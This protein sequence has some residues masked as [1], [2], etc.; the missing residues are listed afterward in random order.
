MS[1]VTVSSS[2]IITIAQASPRD[3]VSVA[4]ARGRR[5]TGIDWIRLA[6]AAVLFLVA[7]LTVLPAPIYAAWLVGLVAAEGGHWFAPVALLTLIP[8]WRR[9]A[10]GR[11]AVAFG[12]ASALLFGAP[13]LQAMRTSGALQAE[14]ART[15]GEAPLFAEDGLPPR[16]SPVELLDLYAGIPIGESRLRT[17][18]YASDAAGERRLDLYL[19][20]DSSRSAP[21]IVMVH[22]GSWRAGDRTELPALARYFAARG[23]AVAVPDYRLA[24]DHPFPAARNDVLAATDFVRLRAGALGIDR[25]RLVYIGRSAG[26][27]LAVSAAMAR[28]NDQAVRGAVSLYG[29]LDLRWGYANPGNPRVLDGRA[30]LRD[31]LG[32]TP[33]EVP[34]VYEA[35]SPVAQVSGRTPPVLLLHGGRDDLVSSEHS[36]RFA[37]RMEWA[38]RPHFVVRLPWATHGCDAIL[39]GPCGQITL[40]AVE[41]FLASTFR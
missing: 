26:A 15:W 23:V 19:P 2:Q 33:S 22:G 27:Q 34:A 40:F 16:V 10:A 20:S 39:R 8:G 11:I 9:S 17:F 24:P 13:L 6:F 25:D 18:E 32:G 21:L 36:E 31:Y 5:R 35:A 4:G 29:P 1:L 38:A 37:A 41:R 3:G 28:P 12:I 7:L 14:L 30:A